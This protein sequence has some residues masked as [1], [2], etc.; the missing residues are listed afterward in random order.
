[1]TTREALCALFVAVL[2]V[3]AGFVWLYG[4]WGLVGGGFGIA[5]VTLLADDI[6]KPK[7]PKRK[8]E[9]ASG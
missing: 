9:E 5:G 2:F 4:A 7:K 6:D 8:K 1:M 3:T